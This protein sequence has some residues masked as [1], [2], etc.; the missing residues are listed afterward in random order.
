[1][2]SE[3]TLA[4][5][6]KQLWCAQQWSILPH[7]GAIHLVHICLVNV[8]VSYC[9]C[10]K[11]PQTQRLETIQI[12]Y[13]TVLESGSPN[14]FY[15]VKKKKI[16]LLEGCVPSGDSRGESISLPFSTSW[17]RLWPLAH[18]PFFYHLGQLHTACSTPSDSWLSCLTLSLSTLWLHCTHFDNPE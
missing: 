10:N 9:C 13:Y 15:W 1:M 14:G 2:S 17:C 16:K 4:A 18:G 7:S 11:F 3:D 12:Y 5:L 6:W 8:L